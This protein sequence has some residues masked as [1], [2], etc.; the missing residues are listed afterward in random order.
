[1]LT[2]RRLLVG[3]LGSALLLHAT[4]YPQTAFAYADDGKERYA[5]FNIDD[6]R[7]IEAWVSKTSASTILIRIKLSN[8]WRVDPLHVSANVILTDANGK[9]LL[10]HNSHIWC[11][12]SL[13]GKGRDR[14]YDFQVPSA[15]VWPA[16]VNVKVVAN[17]EAPR[18]APP[19]TFRIFEM[20]L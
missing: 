1:M 9:Q 4:A 19:P 15:E 18:G 6:K 16:A 12:A 3:C 8:G 14:F 2:A 13:G 17:T 20:P 11:P 10:A 7:F 5:F